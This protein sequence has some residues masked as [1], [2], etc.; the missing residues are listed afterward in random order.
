LVADRNES[1]ASL[2]LPD[3][4]ALGWERPEP[5]AALLVAAV[6]EIAL[7]ELAAGKRDNEL[8]RGLLRLATRTP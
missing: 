8:R 2:M 5:I 3:L 7:L 4:A 6:A 1:A